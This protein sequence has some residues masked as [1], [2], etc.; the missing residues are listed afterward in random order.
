M[1]VRKYYSGLIKTLLGFGAGIKIN[2]MEKKKYITPQFELV[3]L[4]N[5]IA[6]A[7]QSTPPLGPEEFSMILLTNKSLDPYKTEVM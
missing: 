4:D 3:Q 5:E 2:I 1:G 7:L 6:L